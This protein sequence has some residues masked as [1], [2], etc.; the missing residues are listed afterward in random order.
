MRLS[1]M[2]LLLITPNYKVRLNLSVCHVTHTIT[3]FAKWCQRYHTFRFPNVGK[4]A[5]H[6]IR[7][8]MKNKNCG[9]F[10]RVKGKV[11]RTQ[12]GPTWEQKT[13]TS[14]ASQS[15]LPNDPTHAPA[16]VV[17]GVTA[18]TPHDPGMC[19]GVL[20][21]GDTVAHPLKPG[22]ASGTRLPGAAPVGGNAKA[23]GTDTGECRGAAGGDIARSDRAPSVPP[24]RLP[25]IGAAGQMMN[26]LPREAENV[27]SPVFSHSSFF[28]ETVVKFFT[29]FKAGLGAGFSL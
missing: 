5:S 21:A 28:Q 14:K 19:R 17:C 24:A 3:A 4:S 12:T 26:S 10:C 15:S 18:V 8:H 2:H 16:W 20:S 11:D 6:D 27:G 29:T 7:N 23:R 1:G 9:I 13:T 22:V 25:G